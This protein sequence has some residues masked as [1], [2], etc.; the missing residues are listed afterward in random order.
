MLPVL[1]AVS[2]IPLAAEAKDD[3]GPGPIPYATLEEAEKSLRAKPSVKFRIEG[4]WIIAEELDAFTMWLLTP[5]GH[6]AYPSI[7]RRM[8]VNKPEG[9]YMDT[10]VRCL[11][12]KEFCDKAFGSP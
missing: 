3:P 7:V 2:A 6:P 11:A 12:S 1:L 9:A 8:L 4:G 5:K 10:A